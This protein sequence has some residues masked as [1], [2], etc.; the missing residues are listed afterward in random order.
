MSGSVASVYECEVWHQR[1]VPL[2]KA[3]R[4]RVFMLVF[5]LDKLPKIARGICCLSQNAFNLFSV[6][7]RDH[8]D[9]GEPGGI[10][11]N[12]ERWLREQGRELPSGARVQ[13]VTFPRVLG[14]GFNPV[15]FYYLSS[16]SGEPLGAVAEVVNTFREMKLYF[17]DQ[18]GDDQRWQRR[19]EKDFY[20]SPFSDPGD[21]FDFRLGEPA[22]HLRVN[23]D[24]WTDGEKSLVSSI[25][26]ERRPLTTQLL[27]WLAVKYPLLSL[28]IIFGI[29]W[30]AFR[31]WVAKVPFFRKASRIEA[32][33]DVLRPH[34]SLT[35]K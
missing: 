35:P 23:I 2:R 13:L 5:E 32:Q 28:Q 3:F 29:H 4:Y 31:L 25:Q 20:V 19:V 22:A 1:L 15:S 12:L 24:N 10:R 34:S 16:S 8:I 7:D 17:L 21:V 18:Q 33:R 26:G 27:L 6:N 9:L 30:Q 11:P 14:Y